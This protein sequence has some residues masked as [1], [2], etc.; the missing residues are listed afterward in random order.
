MVPSAATAQSVE[1]RRRTT[2]VVVALLVATK[3]AQFHVWPDPGGTRMWPG[4]VRQSFLVGAL[5]LL[6]VRRHGLRRAASKATGE[7]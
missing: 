4:L 5:L 2:S 3:A 1:M 6:L 7:R